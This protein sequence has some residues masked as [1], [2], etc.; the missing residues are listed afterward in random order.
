MNR[1]HTGLARPPQRASVAIVT[2]DN[3]DAPGDAASRAGIEHALQRRALVRGQHSNIHRGDATT[4][5]SRI[6]A[7]SRPSGY[8]VIRL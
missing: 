5:R 1:L 7:P 8:A 4:A 2:D 3:R 6:R